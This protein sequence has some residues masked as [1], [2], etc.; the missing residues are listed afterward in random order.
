MTT[1]F[2]VAHQA[3][4]SHVEF[5][6]NPGDPRAIQHYASAPSLTPSTVTITTQAQAGAAPGDLFLA[7]Y[8]GEGTPGPMIAE[9]DGALVWF[10]PL[11]K[12][13]EPPTSRS[14]SSMASRC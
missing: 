7:P 11:P 4:V 13:Y 3:N 8:Q 6:N 10:H 5:P 14:S 9:Q 2:T 12:G 1:I